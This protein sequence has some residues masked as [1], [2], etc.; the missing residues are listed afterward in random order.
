[1]PRI[2][3]AP[4][5][6][7]VLLP[8][9]LSCCLFTNL[10][11]AQSCAPIENFES[12][13]YTAQV[14]DYQWDYAQDALSYVIRIEVNGKFYAASDMPGSDS[15]TSVKFNPA[16][17]NYDHVH[18]VLTKLCGN[19]ALQK[20]A[21]D[22]IIIDDG[23]VYLDGNSQNGEPNTVE[24][25]FTVNAN[26]VPADRLCGVCDPGFFRLTS[27]FYGPFG[28][29]VAPAIAPIEHLRFRKDELCTCLDNAISAGILDVNGGPGP[30]YD[31]HPFHCE[32][33]PYVFDKK[34]CLNEKGEKTGE[35]S[36]L[37]TQTGFLS[38]EAIPNPLTEFTQFSYTLDHQTN[39]ILS[40]FD[41]SG[42]EIRTLSDKEFEQAGEHQVL[43]D[44]SQLIPGLYFC[45]L[46]AGS[47][48]QTTTLV[49]LAR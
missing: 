7:K 14:A 49:V 47:T 46:Q 24:P 44:A 2:I 30:N 22:F 4:F 27:G 37:V 9:I 1:M 43:F 33:T 35:R 39:T 26:L 8:L 19:G 15:K 40:I 45:R 34:D 21:A 31:G 11:V 48:I 13:Y 42:R 18:A 32:L 23:I 16:L 29:Y 20:S 36:G 41:F 25:V 12:V 6:P 17:K 38:L 5:F 28:I 10:V 3:P